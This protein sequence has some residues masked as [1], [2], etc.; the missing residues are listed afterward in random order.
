[1]KEWLAAARDATW[2]K[3]QTDGVG[4]GLEFSRPPLSGSALLYKEMVVHSDVFLK[5]EP[6]PGEAPSRRTP[7]LDI[8]RQQRSR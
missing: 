3:G 8:R 5:D 2:T 4:L 7:N 1:V 6:D